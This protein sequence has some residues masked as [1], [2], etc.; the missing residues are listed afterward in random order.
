MQAF[1]Y[2]VFVVVSSVIAVLAMVGLGGIIILLITDGGTSGSTGHAPEADR[3]ADLI[4]QRAH[5]SP[6][7][8]AHSAVLRTSP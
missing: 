7:R 6:A 4:A 5:G 1:V 8:P 3:S 2:A